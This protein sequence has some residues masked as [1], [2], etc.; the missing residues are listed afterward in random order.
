MCKCEFVFDKDHYPAQSALAAVFNIL[1]NFVY[2][3]TIHFALSTSQRHVS[4]EF[5]MNVERHKPYV[6]CCFINKKKR[7]SLSNSYKR[8]IIDTLQQS[9]A[10]E[11]MGPPRGTMSVSEGNRTFIASKFTLCIS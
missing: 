8:R 2:Y 4:I 3:S 11:V 9:Q 5:H 7:F 6:K 10:I 1:Q